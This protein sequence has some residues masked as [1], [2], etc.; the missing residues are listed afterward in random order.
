MS[1]WLTTKE[2]DPDSS[3]SGLYPLVFE[4]DFRL[5]DDFGFII[6]FTIIII[7]II[8]IIIM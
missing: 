7:I 1:P 3:A 6:I 8:I 4:M 2:V 5:S